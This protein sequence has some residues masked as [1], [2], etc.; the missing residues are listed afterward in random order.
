MTARHVPVLLEEVLAM[1][2]IRQDGSYI[3]ATVGLGGHSAEIC[4]RLGHG[5]RLLGIDRDDAALQAASE[6]LQCECIT[7]RKAAFADLAAVAGEEGFASCDGILFDLGVSMMQ[8]KDHSR[9][10]SFAS[11][12]RLDMRMDPELIISA[13]DLV[14]KA[15]ERELER[16]LR[17]NGE[18]PFARRIARRICEERRKD[19][20]DTCMQLADIVSAAYGRRGKKHP[21]TRTFQ[22]LRIEVNKELDQLR[23][24]LA[25]AAHLLRTGGRLCVISYHSLEDRVV[26]QFM[27]ENA[28]EGLFG[29]L[30]KKPVVAS[31]PETAA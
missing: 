12:E 17:E 20:I 27:R 10:F 4:A 1:M 7:L 22:A 19:T 15:S 28:R 9:G 21:A 23:D 5:G 26:K 18:E 11:Q 31:R 24:G 6:R 14:N 29:L 13:R 16:I 3:D 30:T 2:A 25:A 8:L